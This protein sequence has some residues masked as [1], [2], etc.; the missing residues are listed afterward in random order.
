MYSF[1]NYYTSMSLE[2][3]HEE[4]LDELFGRELG[5]WQLQRIG[6]KPNTWWQRKREATFRYPT[7]IVHVASAT[8]VTDQDS[9]FEENGRWVEVLKTSKEYIRVP[10]MGTIKLVDEMHDSRDRSMKTRR[11]SKY[12]EFYRDAE[13]TISIQT[14]VKV[15]K[16]PEIQPSQG[17]WDCLMIVNKPP[18]QV[19]TGIFWSTP[20]ESTPVSDVT[21]HI[22]A[23]QLEVFGAS[24]TSLVDYKRSIQS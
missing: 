12:P 4:M 7:E 11:K 15:D 16:I 18:V 23:N 5:D 1:M 17:S 13:R 14:L 3:S 10:A 24:I 8:T 9:S 22:N 19:E 21:L 20:S 2:Q 6:T